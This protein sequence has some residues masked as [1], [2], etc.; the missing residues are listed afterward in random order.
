MNDTNDLMPVMLKDV[1]REAGVST[2]TVDRVLHGRPG[3]RPA[4]IQ[5]V[6]ETIERLGFQPHAAAAE[7]ARGRSSR[8]CFIMPKNLNL[9]MAELVEHLNK[10]RNALAA[11]RVAFDVVETDVFDAVALADT[12]DGLGTRYDG[13]AVVA[14]DHPRVRVAIDELVEKGV[15]IVTLVSDVPTSRRAHY[16]GI[17]NIAAGRT[18]G[19][20]IGRFLAGRRGKVA[21]IAGSLALRDHSERLFGINQVITTEYPGLEILAPVEGRDEDQ[22]NA[23]ITRRL[24]AEHSDLI[25]LYNIGAG[26]SGI[27]NALVESGRGREVVFIGHDLTPQTRRFLLTG[28]MDA[29]IS[30]NPGHEARSATRVLMALVR[31][32]PIIPEQEQIG[33]DIVLRDNLP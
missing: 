25:G 19:T 29:V 20:L 26:T 4:T 23:E 5:R 17:D 13:V 31:N 2:A 6:R 1:A 3:V 16:V 11:R 28:V 14:L 30:Q 12:L 24:L 22:L 8:F 27:G 10:V 21:V 7:L 9:F 15:A 18:V 33:I 32:E